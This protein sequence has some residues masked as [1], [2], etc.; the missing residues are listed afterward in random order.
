MAFLTI[1][2]IHYDHVELKE[3]NE[4]DALSIGQ[5]IDNLILKTLADNKLIQEVT[6]EIG[7]RMEQEKLAEAF[8]R[9]KLRHWNE[10]KARKTFATTIAQ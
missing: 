1:A 10:P 7:G 9:E 5:Q 3:S 8:R 2:T 6:F 4:P